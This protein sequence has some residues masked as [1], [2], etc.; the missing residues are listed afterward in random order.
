MRQLTENVM[1]HLLT[2]YSLIRYGIIAIV[3]LLWKIIVELIEKTAELLTDDTEF[4]FMLLAFGTSL[5]QREA[6]W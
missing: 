6:L 4:C 3:N 1:R 2:D 5:H